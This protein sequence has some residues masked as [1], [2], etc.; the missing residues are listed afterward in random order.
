MVA[1]LALIS[2]IA[3]AVPSGC[4]EGSARPH[5]GRCTIQIGSTDFNILNKEGDVIARWTI[6]SDNNGTLTLKSPYGATATATWWRENGN[7]YINFNYETYTR[8]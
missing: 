5:R 8:M 1:L 4:Y 3:M 6:V 2:V 7:V